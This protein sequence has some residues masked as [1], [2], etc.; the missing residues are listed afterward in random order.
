MRQS[1]CNPQMRHGD[2]F[3][4]GVTVA[5]PAASSAGERAQMRFPPGLER[6]PVGKGGPTVATCGQRRPR[7]AIGGNARCG[8]ARGAK[9]GMDNGAHREPRLGRALRQRIRAELRCARSIVE[10]FLRLGLLEHAGLV[11]DDRDAAVAERIDPVDAHAKTDAAEYQV[12]PRFDRGN[13]ERRPG[14]LDVQPCPQQPVQAARFGRAH[15]VGHAAPP[16]CGQTGHA[17]FDCRRNLDVEIVG[18]ERQQ[19]RPIA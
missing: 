19:P 2:G 14:A 5:T 1:A 18:I 3:G 16:R 15:G 7:R 9:L 17:L 4:R 8:D 13:R 6:A 12:A 10:P 11:V